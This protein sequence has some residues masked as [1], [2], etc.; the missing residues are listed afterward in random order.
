M[1]TASVRIATTPSDKR[2]RNCVEIIQIIEGKSN[3]ITR[4]AIELEASS[5]S[6][7]AAVAAAQSNLK[8]K[9]NKMRKKKILNYRDGLAERERERVSMSSPV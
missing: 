1:W 9:S 6:S 7:S 8:E 3:Q 2:S 5:S 4:R